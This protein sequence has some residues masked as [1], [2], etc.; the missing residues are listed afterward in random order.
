MIEP[1]ALL[2]VEIHVHPLPPH[3]DSGSLGITPDHFFHS[4][5]SVT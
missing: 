5:L 3:T 2:K 1:F 4:E